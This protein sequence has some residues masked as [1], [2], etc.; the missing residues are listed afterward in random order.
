MAG[1]SPFACHRSQCSRKLKVLNIA[2]NQS[3]LLSSHP[4]NKVFLNIN[5][6]LVRKKFER[7]EV[8]TFCRDFALPSRDKRFLRSK[9][10]GDILKPQI[11]LPRRY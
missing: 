2:P 3:F 7:I 8:D 4:H 6:I 5:S 1:I 9:N 10:S 11:V